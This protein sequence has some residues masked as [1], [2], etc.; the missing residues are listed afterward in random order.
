MVLRLTAGATCE[1]KELEEMDFIYTTLENFY[2]PKYKTAKM[3]RK[4]AYTYSIISNKIAILIC[5]LSMRTI[6]WDAYHWKL[7][8]YRLYECL[9]IDTHS[10]RL[11]SVLNDNYNSYTT[12]CASSSSCWTE[13]SIHFQSIKHMKP[14][15]IW[16]K[17]IMMYLL[18]SLIA[19]CSISTALVISL[20]CT[21]YAVQQ[22]ILNTILRR[23]FYYLWKC[24]R[25]FNNKSTQSLNTFYVK[26]SHEIYYPQIT[27][28][29][30]QLPFEP[31]VWRQKN[32]WS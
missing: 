21:A 2:C 6:S 5:Q 7:S 16:M 24:Q 25:C 30:Y 1:S 18:I 26:L 20:I 31:G 29:L 14:T 9:I 28:K 4:Y 10:V 22:I 13:L 19:R 23:L 17:N 15:T 3:Y 32:I 11:R 8:L 12:F 27:I